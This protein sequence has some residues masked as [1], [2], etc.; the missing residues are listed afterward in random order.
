MKLSIDLWS[1]PEGR[2]SLDYEVIGGLFYIIGTYLMISSLL[3]IDG[4]EETESMI[5]S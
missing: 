4:E 3:L 1:L 2:E 5:G